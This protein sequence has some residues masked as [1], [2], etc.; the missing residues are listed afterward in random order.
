MQA[1]PTRD[2]TSNAQR[3]LRR[4]HRQVAR[5]L[6]RIMVVLL[7][8]QPVCL[9]RAVESQTRAKADS[10]KPV[11]IP[12]FVDRARQPGWFPRQPSCSGPKELLVKAGNDPRKA[13]VMPSLAETALF[14]DRFQ[15]AEASDGIGSRTAS[16]PARSSAEPSLNQ[17]SRAARQTLQ[18][19]TL[20]RFRRAQQAGMADADSRKRVHDGV[21]LAARERASW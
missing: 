7:T 16:R 11:V 15:P 17:W 18:N 2:K 8:E 12:S 19:F 14:R 20:A 10:R 5:A 21:F 4:S 1:H 13:R 9:S 6:V 3:G